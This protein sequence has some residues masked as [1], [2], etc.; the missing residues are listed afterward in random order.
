M[1][2][3]FVPASKSLKMAKCMKIW[4]SKGW[5]IITV[6]QGN[7]NLPAVLK[8]QMAF[9]SLSQYIVNSILSQIGDQFMGKAEEF[10]LLQKR[11]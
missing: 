2:V 4:R 9:N 11:N 10:N 3:H 1:A 8:H 5:I 6:S 7:L